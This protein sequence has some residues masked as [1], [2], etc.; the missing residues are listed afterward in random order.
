MAASKRVLGVPAAIA[1]ALIGIIAGSNLFFLS[2]LRERALQ[3]SEEE[4]SRY[5]LTLAENAD[6]SLK[7]VDLVLSSVGD[8]LVRRGAVDATT[9]RVAASDIE[10]HHL[11][12]EKIAGLP[13]LDA[14]TLIDAQGKLL[15]F[16]RYWPIPDVNISDRDYFTTLKADTAPGTV[17]SMPYQNRGDGTWNFYLARRLNDAKGEFMGLMLGALSVPYL[18]NVFGSTSLGLD[19]NVALLRDDGVMIAHFPPVNELGSPSSGFGQRTLAAGGVLREPSRK[20]GE[21]RL[22]AAKMLPSYPATVVVSVSQEHALRSW[23]AMATLL[24]IMSLVSTVAVLAAAVLITRWWRRH[25]HLIHAAEAANAAKSTFVAMMSH[26]IRTPMNAVLGLATTLLE[27][28]L[29]P[30]QRRSVVAIHNAGDSLL[31][32]LNDILDFSKLESGQLSLEDIGFS[33]EA[34]VHNALSIIGPRAAAK[35]LT[36]RSVIDPELPP[37]LIG[38]AGRIRQILLNLVSNAVKFTAAGEV[39]VTTSCVARDGQKATIE[40]SVSDTGIGIA[41]EKIRTLFANFVQAD[42]S[43]NRRFGG[44]GLGLAICKRLTEQM[45]G[46]INVSSTLGRGSTFSFRLTLPIAETAAAPEQNDDGIF[47][48]LQSRIAAF[49]R[50]LRVLV[51][52]DN[53]TNRLVATKML[54]EFDIQTD[55]ACDGAEAV[56][57]ANRFN[58]DLILMDVRMPE[59]D[60]FQ[61][62]RT[63]RARGERR[64][65]VPIIAFTANAFMEDIRAC[66]EAGMNDFVVKPARKKALVEAILRVLPIPMSSAARDTLKG[67][68]APPLQPTE[69]SGSLATLRL[70]TEVA[71]EPALDH[72]AYA[73]LQGEIGEEAAREIHS[74]FIS[75]TDARLKL[76]RE[77]SLNR[78]RIRIGREAHSLKSA[79]GTFG[80]RRLASLALAL[81]KS[82]PRLSKEDYAELLDSID[83]AYAAAR[84]QEL[85]ETQPN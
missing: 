55:T 40:W 56:T 81:E 41:P 72:E 67:S 59:M 44:S 20:T 66:R 12:K 23:R 27:T 82:A 69:T 17:I 70:E 85:E 46:E 61:A 76:L 38:D 30:E 32:I 79:A 43:I 8:Y 31:E 83:A 36:I 7:S 26:E 45:G 18:E 71:P 3:E 57:A 75:E 42:A 1:L 58:Y 64:S 80:Y 4:L 28:D 84:A 77:L 48:A 35:D 63:I 39:I 16:S 25:E 60:G 10:T 24:T 47:A 74:V 22:R 15:N 14:V 2:N 19:A 21:A 68:A 53:P 34:M 51:V 33:A 50:P 78:E 73:E 11:L 49:G 54:K 9:F 6:R 62:T 29:D 37:A 13:Q 5:S 65:E 52:D